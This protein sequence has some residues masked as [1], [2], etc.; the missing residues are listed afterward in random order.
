MEYECKI[1]TL[2]EIETRMNDI[3][4]TE[5]DNPLLYQAKEYAING[6]NE[7][8]RIMYI[9][10]L[11]GKTICEAT[12][13]IDDKA[14]CNET[15]KPLYL[16]QDNRVYLSYAEVNIE[17]E[18]RGYFS[19]LMDFVADDLLDKGYTELSIGLKPED[20][21]NMQIFFKLGFVYYIKTTVDFPHTT[22]NATTIQNIKNF[23]YKK[24]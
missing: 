9:G 19:K 13:Y 6:Y 10:K 21:I 2:E 22:D 15:T 7:K 12:V 18:G 8:N 3:I 20:T 5:P 23:Y 11:G 4:A 16:I 24:L 17:Y 14:F 1:A